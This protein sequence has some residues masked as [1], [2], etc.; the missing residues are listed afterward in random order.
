MKSWRSQFTSW[1][2]MCSLEQWHP[3]LSRTQRELH[4]VHLQK[5]SGD[6]RG[7]WQLSPLWIS[8]LFPVAYIFSS[9]LVPDSIGFSPYSPVLHFR[10]QATCLGQRWSPARVAR[11]RADPK[12][13]PALSSAQLPDDPTSVAT[14]LQDPTSGS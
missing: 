2:S 11:N 5:V 12:K 8:S 1:C 10:L 6:Y 3:G 4:E 9:S 13:S 14:A 7:T